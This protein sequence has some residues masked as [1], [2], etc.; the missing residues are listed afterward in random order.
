MQDPRKRRGATLIEL[1]VALLLFDLTLLALLAASALTAGRIGD[2]NRRQR[3]LAAATNRA[4]GFIAAPCGL[5]ISGR[6]TLERGMEENWSSSLFAAGGAISDSVVIVRDRPLV[7]V[8][9]QVC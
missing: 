1:I 2:A 9:A 8:A 5:A 7:I 6:L 4:E 3:A